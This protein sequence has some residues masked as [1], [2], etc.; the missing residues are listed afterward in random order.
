[1]KRSSLIAVLAV[2]A[3]AI[4]VS[5]PAIA[6]TSLT[7]GKQLCEAAAKAQ[8]PAPKSV[9]TDNDATRVNDSTLTYTLRIRSADDVQGVLTCKVDRESDTPTL[10]SAS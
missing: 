5:G 9:R 4:A 8:T 7:K 3:T 6:K 2:A 1:M 10:T